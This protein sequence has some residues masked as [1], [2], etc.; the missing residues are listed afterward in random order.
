[1]NH[2][3]IKIISALICVFAVLSAVCLYISAAPPSADYHLITNSD[4][5]A[6]IGV[7]FDKLFID[8]TVNPDFT[9][10]NN[11]DIIIDF[12]V[13][14]NN[15]P[16]NYPYYS[17]RYIQGRDSITE[18]RYERLVLNPDL[19]LNNE[20]ILYDNGW[21]EG[22]NEFNSMSWV[23]DPSCYIS[24]VY[25]S[26]NNN[27]LYIN[28]LVPNNYFLI[29]NNMTGLIYGSDF[30]QLKIRPNGKL[31]LNDLGS[32]G[33]LISL[34]NNGNSTADFIVL[35]YNATG[36]SAFTLS[37]QI[38]S[39]SEL[40]GSGIWGDVTRLDF[41]SSATGWNYDAVNTFNNGDYSF[42]E[43]YTLNYVRSNNWNSFLYTTDIII[44]DTVINWSYIGLVP[45]KL[46]GY[47]NHGDTVIAQFY[48]QNPAYTALNPSITISGVDEFEVSYSSNN[49][50]S[51]DYL[52]LNIEFVV[53]ELS[54]INV[55]ITPKLNWQYEAGEH[56][57]YNDGYATGKDEGYNEGYDNG[58]DDGIEIGKAEGEKIGFDKGYKQW[59]ID[60]DI[61]Q[62]KEE[63]YQLGFYN[64]SLEGYQNGL[65]Q[66]TS[67]K[68][69]KDIFGFMIPGSGHTTIIEALNSPIITFQ[70][71]ALDGTGDID[72]NISI[73]TVFSA[74]VVIFLLI[75][76]LKMFAGG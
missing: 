32:S 69:I 17:I 68:F 22:V 65:D 75:W 40:Y 3:S 39:T 30:E 9:G 55:N 24:W 74:I 7:N 35:E 72:I 1:M 4:S 29:D 19:P 25:S 18:Q 31:D 73:T 51:I 60:N 23:N 46:E 41:Y 44:R 61:E 76:F 15:T 11:N 66:G 42:L 49:G 63:E 33:W 2:K 54:E 37:A 71:P 34:S 20:I 64:G 62:I 47:V 10:L 43:G 13:R 57:G 8:N 58:K 70:M 52:V 21:T 26:F 36:E 12:N 5:G 14:D 6:K 27:F 56:D 50:N 38:P 48:A 59:P 16:D 53:P 45:L 67:T 28:D